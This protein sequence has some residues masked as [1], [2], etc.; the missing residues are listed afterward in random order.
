MRILNYSL[1]VLLALAMA[2]GGDGPAAVTPPGLPCAY[3]PDILASDPKCVSPTDTRPVVRSLFVG[4]KDVT[5]VWFVVPDNLPFTRRFSHSPCTLTSS[6]NIGI[7][8]AA[9]LANGDSASLSA[10]LF[11]LESSDTTVIAFANT[12]TAQLSTSYKRPGATTITARYRDGMALS[13][14]VVV[15]EPFFS[16]PGECYANS[17]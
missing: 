5:G 1:L 6:N 17:R 11:D 12:R 4:S 10:I 15:G 7:P 16:G 9:V 14:S 2:C 8:L 13:K 3:N